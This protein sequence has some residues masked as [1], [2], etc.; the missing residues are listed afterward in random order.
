MGIIQRLFGSKSE[1][2][3]DFT[4]R[5]KHAQQERKI[6]ELLTERA[7][8]SNQR[9]LERYTK[10]NEEA[11]I[12]EA[13]EHIHKKQNTEMWKSKNSMLIGQK[14]ILKDDRPILQEK[15]IFKNNPNLF[16]KKHAIKNHTDM[17]FFK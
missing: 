2:N 1:E 8:S 12:K 17:G 7:K 10:E 6:E 9:E 13:L 3:K 5:F 16:T 4:A 14:S 15:N 11:Q